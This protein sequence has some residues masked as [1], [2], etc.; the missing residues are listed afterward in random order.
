MIVPTE[1]RDEAGM[2]DGMKAPLLLILGKIWPWKQEDVGESLAHQH[3]HL[4]NELLGRSFCDALEHFLNI[5][6]LIRKMSHMV[7]REISKWHAE[8][9]HTSLFLK[10]SF[11][12]L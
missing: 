2:V 10:G 12:F 1:C 9:Q 4:I 7:A 11:F 6:M 8:E 3:L 5:V